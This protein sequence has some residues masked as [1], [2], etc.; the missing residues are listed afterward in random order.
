M[1]PRIWTVPRNRSVAEETPKSFLGYD[2]NGVRD[3]LK[4]SDESP[5]CGLLRGRSCLFQL[6][7]RHFGYDVPQT[8]DALLAPEEKLPL[9]LRRVE[10]AD[11]SPRSPDSQPTLP[12]LSFKDDGNC[13]SVYCLRPLGFVILYIDF[14]CLLLF[15]ELMVSSLPC[16]RESVTPSTTRSED[17]KGSDQRNVF[18]VTTLLVCL[19]IFLNEGRIAFAGFD[20]SG[21]IAAQHR[22]KRRACERGAEA[23]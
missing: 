2:W 3:T 18:K 1:S 23:S 16:E 17:S 7:L 4:G 12:L 14:S 20:K 22:D 15:L 10:A 21:P 8:I 11:L 6:C 9:C 19:N 13:W 5:S